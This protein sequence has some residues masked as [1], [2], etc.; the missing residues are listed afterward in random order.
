MAKRLVFL[1]DDINFPEDKIL[2]PIK[3]LGETQVHD[4]VPEDVSEEREEDIETNEGL[5]DD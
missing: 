2:I 5:R 4:S 1:K 3:H